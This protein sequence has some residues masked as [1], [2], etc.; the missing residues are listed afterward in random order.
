M[1]ASLKP[2]TIVVTNL[3]CSAFVTA[4]AALPQNRVDTII[5]SRALFELIQ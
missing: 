5:G 1:A 3:L 2:L 4:R